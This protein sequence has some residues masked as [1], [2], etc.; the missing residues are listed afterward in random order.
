VQKFNIPNLRVGTLDSLMALSDELQKKDVFVEN[1]VKKI[2]RQLVELFIEGSPKD[3][4]TKEKI[5]LMVNNVNLDTYLRQFQWDEAKYKRNSPLSE[6]IDA[7]VST[8]GKLDEE[9]RTKAGAYQAVTHSILADQRKKTGN[10]MVREI[11][12]LIKPEDY[13][14]SEN[15]CTLFVVVA[16]SQ[17]REWDKTYEDM[18][19]DPELGG[20]VVPRSAVV[21]ADDGDSLLYSIVLFRKLAEEFKKEARKKK[22]AIRDHA[23]NPENLINSDDV[24]KK[25]ES[26]KRKQQQ[27]LTRWCR[28][29]FAEA[30]VAWT[31][32][33][34]VRVFIET[35]LR[36]GL[37]A[38][39]TAI[40]LEPGRKQDKKLRALLDELYKGMG[41]VYT[42][43]DKEEDEENALAEKFYSYVWSS[44]GVV[45]GSGL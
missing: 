44:L 39:F 31:H 30:F 43:D 25:L 2:A 33:K 21:I 26:K 6:I 17:N 16:K 27:N 38:D 14:D 10:L 41:S 3:K 20:G 15:L 45:L 35:I 9:M 34:T 19:H 8:V 23:Y 1:T 12:D 29:N 28:E 5:Q 18:L 40:L 22:Y 7:I 36:Y 32:L 37:P 42:N 13:V 4:K 24:R 11:A